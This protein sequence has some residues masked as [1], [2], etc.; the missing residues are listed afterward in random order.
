MTLGF[1]QAWFLWLLVVTRAMEIYTDPNCSRTTDPE[2][3]LGSRGLDVTIV[4]VATQISMALV[5]A[6]PMDT[7]MAAG[8]SQDPRHL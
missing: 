5:A 4:P 6:W 8:G 1:L 7:N 2:V 3:A